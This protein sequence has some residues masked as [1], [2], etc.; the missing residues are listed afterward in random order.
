M[1]NRTMFQTIDLDM[2]ALT[3]GGKPSGGGDHGDQASAY[4]KDLKKDFQDFDR[5]KRASIDA[6]LHGHFIEAGK[7][8]LASQIDSAKIVKD[9]IDPFKFF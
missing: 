1:N 4:K 9:A 8:H 7:Q 3:T 2:L 6:G 5:R